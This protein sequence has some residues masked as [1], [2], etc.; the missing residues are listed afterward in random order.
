M[1]NKH[2]F[3]P[4]AMEFLFPAKLDLRLT[5]NV[6]RRTVAFETRVRMILRIKP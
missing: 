5:G 6:D 2:N 1:A 3:A 4:D